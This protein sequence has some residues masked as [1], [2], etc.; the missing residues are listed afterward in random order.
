MSKLTLE[1]IAK[2]SGVSRSMIS[3]VINDYPN[4]KP[5]VRE[6]I[7]K[8]VAETGYHPDPAARLLA[9]RRTGIIGLVVPLAVHLLFTDPFIPR[10][11][12]G[13]TQACNA[14]DYT[15][16][17]IVLNTPEEE[18]KLYP[19]ILHT[20]MFDGVIIQAAPIGDPLIRQMVE[21][22]VPPHC[23]AHRTRYSR[24]VRGG[25]E[26]DSPSRSKFWG[27]TDSL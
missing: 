6:R 17:L 27:R 8:V 22:T 1:K 23:D 13:I 3:R 20:Q 16:S 19:R 2:L 11:L 24:V 14:N 10:L 12:H 9:G 25:E 21:H 5:K 4:V 18:T 7:L 15:L 26:L